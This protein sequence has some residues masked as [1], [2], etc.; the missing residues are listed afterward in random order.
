MRH[1]RSFTA[2]LALAAVLAACTDDKKG[3]DPTDGRTPITI[4]A[5]IQQNDGAASADAFGSAVSAASLALA[6][7]SLALT[8]GS[9]GT[10]ATASTRATDDAWQQDDAIGL[11]LLK[12]GTTT[13]SDGQTNYRYMTDGTGTFT[14]A[15]AANTAYF[16]AADGSKVDILAYYPYTRAVTPTAL[17]VPV[18]LSSQAVPA[19]IDLMTAD[20]AS[21]I[22]A[23]KPQ[24]DLTFVHRLC[25][26]VL[27]LSKDPAF[28]D[29][30]LVGARAV[31]RGTPVRGTWDLIAATLTPSA[32]TAALPLTL[33]A[34]GT[35]ATAI[36]MP[37]AATS[38][39]SITLTTAGGRS[40][41]TQLPADFAFAPGTQNEY[42]VTLAPTGLV[43]GNV[44]IIPWTDGVHASGQAQ[45]DGIT[46]PSSTLLEVK[47]AGK[48]LLATY[49]ADATIAA[50]VTTAADATTTAAAT[51]TYPIIYTTGKAA[52]STN[53]ADGYAPILWESLDRYQSGT[54]LQNY[55]YA[56]GFLPD[57]YSIDGKPTADGAA[58]HHEKDYLSATAAAT[59]WGTSPA[60][61]AEGHKLAHLMALY[62]VELASDGTYNAEA[63]NAARLTLVRK[64]ATTGTPAI[65][66][67]GLKLTVADV[68]L[69][70]DADRAANTVTLV[71]TAP[72]A[73]AA[74]GTPA[75]FAAILCPQTLAAAGDAYLTLTLGTGTAAKTY[76]LSA[77]ADAPVILAAGTRYTLKATVLKTGVQPAG[78][79][80]AP[81]TEAG[82]T[83]DFEP[84]L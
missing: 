54:T 59:P 7:G 37:G 14:P 38:G 12:S 56:A 46:L 31:L 29:L 83:G 43:L 67:T 68:T 26:L 58:L 65:D 23:Q 77:P 79:A 53:P 42:S 34:D 39:R 3:Q 22:S 62:T 17:T 30:N 76:T 66:A 70:T 18:D 15:D 48:L 51:G 4:L 71:R 20:P 5:S 73:D 8:D 36:V 63:L 49:K 60:F 35:L 11:V 33:S 84:N 10:S 64:R 78:I 74:A 69:K 41:T 75:T 9:L 45:T 16:P 6:D 72:A 81:W 32:E 1:Y 57:A 24:V 80:L 28:A 61:D 25:K 2:A 13:L 40:L 27:K 50:D 47:E 82:G 44:T 19:A 52:I 21:R 55:A